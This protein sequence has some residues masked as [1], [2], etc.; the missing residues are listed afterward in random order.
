MLSNSVSTRLT[1]LKGVPSIT[2][3]H[4]LRQG[5]RG[6]Q[7]VAA[8]AVQFTLQAPGGKNTPINKV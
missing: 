4:V 1:G 6:L 7:Q 2:R 5:R 8:K 3:S